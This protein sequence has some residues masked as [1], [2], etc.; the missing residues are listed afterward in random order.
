MV[1][2]GPQPQLP[3]PA[4]DQ[5]SKEQQDMIV[6]RYLQECSPEEWHRLLTAALT[7]CDLLTVRFLNGE[8]ITV[9]REPL[10]TIGDMKHYLRQLRGLHSMQDLKLV[11]DEVPLADK[12]LI[13]TLP[14]KEIQAVICA[15]AAWDPKE[16]ESRLC[17]DESGTIVSLDVGVGGGDN[18]HL[19]GLVGPFIKDFDVM[20]AR[21]LVKQAPAPTPQ[22]YGLLQICVG[23]GFPGN[24]LYS[25]Y[26]T[27]FRGVY[28]AN[29]KYSDHCIGQIDF[30][31]GD[32]V[33]VQVDRK[34]RCVRFVVQR[35]EE[36]VLNVE[37][38]PHLFPR[39]DRIYVALCG[40]SESKIE[41]QVV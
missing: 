5:L 41:V 14:D 26:I 3:C 8:S 38:E 6:S 22:A 12:D 23:E 4:M 24:K 15:I 31:T 25:F 39:E 11:L 32:I 28:I 16:K 29:R 10:A 18:P 17:I 20:T 13:A 30:Q 21:L 1:A 33:Q 40:S 37:S 35:G 27:R 19:C 36:N 34:R 9:K 2:D 7:R